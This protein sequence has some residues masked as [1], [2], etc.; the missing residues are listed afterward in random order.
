MIR[1]SSICRFLNHYYYYNSIHCKNY[2]IR[3]IRTNIISNSNISSSNKNTNYI[4]QFNGSIM[5][6]NRRLLSTMK[7][8]KDHYDIEVEL[9]AIKRS[10]LNQYNS[11][12][13]EGIIII[14]I[15]IIT[16][17]IIII[18]NITKVH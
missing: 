3:N 2:I 9:F 10:M 11:G 5:N 14:I 16:I 12:N 13:Y 15:T 17:I 8:N 1:K 7:D 4:L 6:S 18:T